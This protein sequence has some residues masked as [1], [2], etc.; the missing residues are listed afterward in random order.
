MA[1]NLLSLRKT[2]EE[3]MGINYKK[4]YA[5]NDWWVD[6]GANPQATPTHRSYNTA[7]QVHIDHHTGAITYTNKRGSMVITIEELHKM[8]MEAYD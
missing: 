4:D 3:P 6:P 1:M 2:L 7:S 8:L 5:T